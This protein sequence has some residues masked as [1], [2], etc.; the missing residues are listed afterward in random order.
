MYGGL[1]STF[2]ALT[3]DL[4]GAK[5]MA[6]NYGFVLIGFG[7]ASVLATQIAGHFRNI[8]ARTG[9]IEDMIPAFL[10]AAAFSLGAIAL[11]WILR[12]VDKRQ[13]RGDGV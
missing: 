6:T 11:I 13:V 7:I 1:L 8:A 2:P 5:H 4:F 10:I 12:I 9:N 3:A